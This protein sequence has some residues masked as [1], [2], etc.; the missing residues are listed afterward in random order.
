MLSLIDSVPG[1]VKKLPTP[2]L[3]PETDFGAVIDKM[4]DKNVK[5]KNF[6]QNKLF[7]T[8]KKFST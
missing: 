2:N 3:R 8:K 4:F 1:K 5:K 6:G 7:L